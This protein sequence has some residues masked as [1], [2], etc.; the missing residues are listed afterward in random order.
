M[1][2]ILTKIKRLIIQRKYI[3]TEKADIERI[4][5]GLSE[6]DVLESILNATFVRVKNS[7]SPWRT[8]RR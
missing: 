6:E 2:P 8:G 3:F 5:D 7:R 4:A 1:D